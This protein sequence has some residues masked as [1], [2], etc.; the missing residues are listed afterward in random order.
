MNSW[1]MILHPL[2]GVTYPITD[3]FKIGLNTGYN[4][5]FYDITFGFGSFNTL[6]IYQLN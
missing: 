4:L 5:M 3:R 1:G 6:L 2:I